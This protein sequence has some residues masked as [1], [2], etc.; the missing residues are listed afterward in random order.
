MMRIASGTAD[1]T[2]S[3]GDEPVLL[4][5]V[6]AV[7]VRLE[8]GE[9]VDLEAYHRE[10]PA[11]AERLRRLLPA[12][13]M[14]ADLARSPEPESSRAFG[15]GAAPI[16]GPGTLGDYRIGPEIGRGGMGVV[17]EAQQISLCRRVALKVLPFASAIDP[18]HLQRFKNESM[19]AAH[20]HHP[21]IVPVHA[22]GCERGVHYYAMQ[23]IDGQPMSA[24]I[25]ELRR[26]EARAGE[27]P[28]RPDAEVFA[29][30]C[31]MTSGRLGGSGPAPD[32]DQVTAEYDPEEPIPVPAYDA[33]PMVAAPAR[34]RALPPGA[35][36]SS[37]R[38]PA[39]GRRRPTRSS[40]PMSRG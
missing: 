10:D 25:E 38:S 26:I 39:W 23:F 6:E 5:W 28:P 34:R 29:M 18:K 7:K 36:S 32:A 27:G 9:S 24:L 17:Y 1:P 16:L 20:L 21:N 2:Q 30:A 19:A 3:I 40:M 33:R 13:G 4:E 15:P 14:M 11:R 22:V 37:R 35:G 12:I 31:G 8:A